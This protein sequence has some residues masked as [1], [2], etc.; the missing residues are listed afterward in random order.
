[1][2]IPLKTFPAAKGAGMRRSPSGRLPASLSWTLKILGT[3]FLIGITTAA[4]FACIFAIYVDRYINTD[5]DVNP[6]DFQVDLT[7]FIY[8]Y[9]KSTGDY[10]VL[11]E[12]HAAENRV[13]ASYDEIPQY[14]LDAVVAIEDKRFYVHHGVDWYRT[15]GAFV[16]MFLGM[17]N[18]FGGSTL[19][20][21]LIKNLTEEDDVTVRR[22]ITEIF[23]ALDFE[24]KYSKEDILEM[25]L[26][27]VYFSQGCH[28]VQ[29]AA[30]TYFGKDVKDLSLA[31]ATC[32]I[33][34]TNLPTY[35][36][37]YINREN[38][39]KRQ[40]N[41]LKQM[42]EQHFITPEQRDT[43]IAEK[44]VF[45]RDTQTAEE[46]TEK[47][48]YQSYFVDQIIED[49]LNDMVEQ[50]G[51]SYKVATQLL[52]RGG[53]RIYA[54]VD[55]D[56]QK[57]ID[58]VY[59]NEKY[60][61]TLTNTNGN[62]PQS[63]IVVSDPAT[64]NILGMYGGLGEK[65]GNRSWNRATMTKRQPGSSIKPIAVYAP[66][67]E[68][69]LITPYSVYTDMPVDVSDGK[70]P[71]PKN[72][73]IKTIGYRGQ[74]TI[75]EAVQSSINTV[76]AR[77]VTDMG[78]QRCFEFAKYKMGLS[79]LVEKKTIGSKEYSDIHVASMSLGGLTDGVT[80][81]EM[82][83]AY[84]V[85]PNKGIYNKSRTYTKVEDSSGK[86]VL[87]NQ[88]SSTP[89][90][91]EKTAYYMNVLLQ[92]V[93]TNGTGIN[94]RLENMP[95]AGKTGTTDDD[96]DRWFA[97]YT[98]YYTCVVWY[99]FDVNQ[100][101]VTKSGSSPAVPLWKA[102]MAKINAD[103]PKKDFFTPS[104]TLVKASYCRDSGDAPTEACRNDIRGSRVATGT[105]FSEDVPSEPCSVHKYVNMDSISKQL[106]T[107]Y[108]PAA[109]IVRLAMLD[110]DRR[111][112]IPGV[113]VN[114][115]RY[116]IRQ[117][118][119]PQALNPTE[120]YRVAVR[121]PKG[122][123]QYNAFCTLHTGEVTEPP[124]Q[125][126]S[127]PPSPSN[128]PGTDDGESPGGGTDTPPD[129]TNT[130]PSDPGGPAHTDNP[131]QSPGNSGSGN[132]TAGDQANQPTH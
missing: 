35:Y 101:I 60:W 4:M 78:P 68:S 90:I 31:E 82:A 119:D 39:K 22:K 23:R 33:G 50:K 110:L 71:W 38:N 129:G 52:Y 92:N 108:C 122:E 85:F 5:L 132:T 3:V 19:T 88:Q 67:I 41:I 44:I 12:L 64:G 126:P 43:A 123:V 125:S 99:G 116:T 63:A 73:D 42:C 49:V 54:T 111:L 10:K 107:P 24:R 25:Y 127:T 65:T 84:S 128:S 86:V 66:A 124:S 53:Y 48:Q 45:R 2:V 72:Y 74:V 81:R 103:L 17:R 79:S 109:S 1:M 62:K 96:Y 7:S 93:V 61:P 130:S 95:A 15:S 21:Q 77:L 115:E 18:N 40:E 120:S 56:V 29:A 34:I 91:K 75:M 98:P 20:Q 47:N 69:G 121:V 117:Y 59:S 8:Y 100:T 30:Q 58:E 76:A 16:N 27:L 102:V 37:P 46:K 104:G 114:D 118:S 80:V 89:V 36:D 87:D 105:F 113:V 55:M 6:E 14:M 57:A 97:G 83:E 9:D 112:A 70:N 28:G 106:A 94:A 26:N 51:I 131:K 11:D 32:I 13:W